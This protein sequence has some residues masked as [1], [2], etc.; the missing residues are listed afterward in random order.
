MFDHLS[1]LDISRT[2]F[3]SI[4]N[5]QVQRGAALELSDVETDLDD[6][7]RNLL[8]GKLAGGLRQYG[9]PVVI[10]TSIRSP[11]P[12]I[13]MGSLSRA[14]QDFVEVSRHVAQFFY[15][16]QPTSSAGGV[17]VMADCRLQLRRAVALVMLEQVAGSIPTPRTDGGRTGST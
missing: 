6:T 3:H 15:D 17:F 8:R 5:K 12:G 2:V 13:V 14:D 4:P 9:H 1:E 10:D 7:N 16:K 11:V